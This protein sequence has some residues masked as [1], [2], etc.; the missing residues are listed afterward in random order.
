MIYPVPIPPLHRQLSV[1]L[2]TLIY[3]APGS[4]VEL[5]VTAFNVQ[6]I[7][8]SWSKFGSFF[9]LQKRHTPSYDE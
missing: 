7:R 3:V 6:I 5:V 2:S 4:S 1:N 9:L 8:T